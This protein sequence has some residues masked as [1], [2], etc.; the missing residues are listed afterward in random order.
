MKKNVYRRTVL[1]LAIALTYSTAFAIRTAHSHSDVFI[2]AVDGQVVIGGAH[3]LG[4]AEEHYDL[5][6]RVFEG[7]LIPNFP[8]FDPAD[9]GRDEPGFVAL[10]SGSA[11]LPAG[12]AALPVSADVVA[13]PQFF[14][15][16]ASTD[17][18]FYWNGVRTVDFQ[19]ISS[20]QPGVTLTMD[21][22]PLGTTGGDGSLHEHAAFRL[23]NGGAGVPLDGVYLIS[24]TANVSGLAASDSFYIVFL[25]D[26][27]LTD[28]D[29][30]EEL[31]GALELGDTIVHGKDFAFFEAAVEYVEGN[32]VV[33][34][35]SSIL[36]SFMAFTVLSSRRALRPGA[37]GEMR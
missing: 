10:A 26:Q 2:T 17:A 25:V 18:L 4:T 34:E 9:Y 30:A 29:T 22:N 6:T 16:G 15:I 1:V 11:L 24:P 13:Q 33:P 37:R 35:P 12:A 7:V 3:D 21:P 19:P 28:E 20:S 31:E 23:D 36:L 32:L 8:P 5:N 27:L 14:T